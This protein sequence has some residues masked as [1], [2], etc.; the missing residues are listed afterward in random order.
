MGEL[1]E[2]RRANRNASERRRLFDFAWALTRYAGA[3]AVGTALQYLI[4]MAGVEL[5]GLAP[6]VAAVLGAVGATIVNYT[7]NYHL[8]FASTRSHKETFPR[9]VCAALLSVLL[10]GALV[11][12][13]TVH[14]GLHYLLGQLVATGTVVIT[15]FV[16]S[17][18]WV[19][20]GP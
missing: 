2:T 3:G 13:T 20:R 5:L 4:L 15:G 12:L 10:T 1:A 16:V 17:K 6:V 19:F 14:L 8:T 18:T 7:L 11:E 9:F